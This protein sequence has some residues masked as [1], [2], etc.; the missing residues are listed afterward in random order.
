[1]SLR[2]TIDLEYGTEDEPLNVKDLKSYIDNKVRKAISQGLLDAD[3]PSDGLYIFD[4][5]VKVEEVT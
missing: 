2:I 5:E 3:P 4:W 1:M